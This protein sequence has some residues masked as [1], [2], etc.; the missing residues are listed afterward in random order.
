MKPQVDPSHYSHREYLTPARMASYSYQLKEILSLS[1]DNALELGVGSGF[2]AY[3]LRQAGFAVTTLDF[4]LMLKPNVVASVTDLPFCDNS[5]D[6]VGCF[7]VLEH[8]PWRFFS[9][10]LG[11]IHRVCRSHAIIS[12]PDAWPIM[13][14]HIPPL[15]RRC[16]FKI[17]FWWSEKHEFDGEHYWEINKKGYPLNK[18]MD[19]LTEVGFHVEHTYRPWEVCGHRFFQLKKV[20]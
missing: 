15:F 8:I 3:G 17:P 5:Y 7:E 2:F 16:K 19:C 9:S 6:V 12:L 10:A 1:F 20:K 14:V 18:V 11:E 13:R 4:D